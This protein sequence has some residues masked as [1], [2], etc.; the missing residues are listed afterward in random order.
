MQSWKEVKI[1]LELWAKGQIVEDLICYAKE[2]RLC[3]KTVG[4]H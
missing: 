4:S 1:T 2:F 3:P